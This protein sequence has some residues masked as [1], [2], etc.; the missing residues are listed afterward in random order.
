MKRWDVFDFLLGSA[1]RQH[2]RFRLEKDCHADT[3]FFDDPLHC[4]VN[5]RQSAVALAI[6]RTQGLQMD[7]MLGNGLERLKLR[8]ETVRLEEVS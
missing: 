5:G 8:V 3:F 1:R 6:V 4:S 7:I 2:L